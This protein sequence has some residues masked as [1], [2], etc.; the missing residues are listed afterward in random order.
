MK[1]KTVE[2]LGQILRGTVHKQFKKCGKPNCKC[3]RGELHSTYYYFVR[4]DGKLKAQYLKAS[5]VE[6]VQQACMLRRSLKKEQRIASN[7]AWQQLRENRQSL[8]S[9]TDLYNR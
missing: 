5:E 2:V 6:K 9:V 7:K 3:A 8:Q 4:M 1:T